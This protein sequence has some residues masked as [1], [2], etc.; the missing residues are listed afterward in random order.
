MTTIDQT[1]RQVPS[2]SVPLLG[3]KSSRLVS[4]EWR[5]TLE[6]RDEMATTQMLILARTN[7]VNSQ[8]RKPLT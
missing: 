4:A 6:G 5:A 1:T 2:T 8:N 7:P 3:A